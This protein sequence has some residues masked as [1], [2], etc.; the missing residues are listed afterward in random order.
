MKSAHYLYCTRM[1]VCAFASLNA[2]VFNTVSENECCGKNRRRKRLSQPA[3]KLME[4]G[5]RVKGRVKRKRLSTSNKFRGINV[6][7]SP[8]ISKGAP[9]SK[10]FNSTVQRGD[11]SIRI[12][13]SDRIDR[14]VATMQAARTA[15]RN[16]GHCQK[17]EI[18]NCVLF[19]SIPLLF[20]IYK[21]FHYQ[22]SQ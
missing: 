5:E 19:L 10:L 14:P 22:I 21:L 2:P 18:N 17:R 11:T 16:V 6:Q 9:D 15:E 8:D 20:K 7:T 3:R 13:N 1:R 4:R 12:S